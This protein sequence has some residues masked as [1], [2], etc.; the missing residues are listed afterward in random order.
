MNT[1]K[2]IGNKLMVSKE[3]AERILSKAIEINSA[4]TTGVGTSSISKV[5]EKDV[6][7]VLEL[8]SKRIVDK[9]SRLINIKKLEKILNIEKSLYEEVAEDPKFQ[10]I[11]NMPERL[12]FT[13]VKILFGLSYGRATK[14]EIWSI[15]SALETS[16]V[17]PGFDDKKEIREVLTIL[18]SYNCET[19]ENLYNVEK[20]KNEGPNM[21]GHPTVYIDTACN[22]LVKI[23]SKKGINLE[24]I[25]NPTVSDYDT[26]G[27]ARPYGNSRETTD[28]LFILTDKKGK[29]SSISMEYFGWSGLSYEKGIVSKNIALAD[30]F[31]HLY[32]VI[33]PDKADNEAA[34]KRY[35]GD[36]FERE[37]EGTELMNLE[38]AAYR[39]VMTNDKYTGV[40]R[41]DAIYNGLYACLEELGIAH[42][43][44]P[45]SKEELFKRV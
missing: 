21:G 38:K 29:K 16:A 35:M 19:L 9:S 31:G 18:G 33:S 42:R 1:N 14:D 22:K 5:E 3:L 12:R 13:A 24:V 43:V 6:R 44:M 36:L 30:E 23:A 34:M 7:N 39:W 32:G 8:L 26:R 27:L 4:A 25:A 10:A 28:A 11:K 20:E 2:K 45:A 15:I 41:A 40:S 17:D 37:F